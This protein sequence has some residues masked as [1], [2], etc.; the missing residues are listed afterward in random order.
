MFYNVAILTFSHFINDYCVSVY[1]SQD[2]RA[3]YM[4]TV[5]LKPDF[6][7]KYAFSMHIR[8]PWFWRSAE[9]CAVRHSTLPQSD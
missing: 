1:N 8:R 3:L 5:C 6:I 4:K 9:N 2:H 7:S